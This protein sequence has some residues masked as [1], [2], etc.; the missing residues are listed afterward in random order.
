MPPAPAPAPAASAVNLPTAPGATSDPNQAL[1]NEQNYQSQM[2]TGSQ[3]QTAEEN[4][5]GVGAAQTQVSGLRQAITNTTNLLNQV[6]PSVYGRTQSSLET[7]AQAGRQISNE[8]APISSNLKSQTTAEANAESDYNNL[9]KEATTKASMDESS[10]Q[11][12]LTNLENTY[13]DLYTQQQAQQ[14][15]AANAAAEAEKQSEFQQTLSEKTQNDQATQNS[16][17]IKAQAASTKAGTPSASQNTQAAIQGMYSQLSSQKGSDGFISPQSYAKG[18]QAWVSA[19]LNA[20]DYDTYFAT[21][22]N[23]N[24][25]AYLLSTG[26]YSGQGSKSSSAGSSILSKLGI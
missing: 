12:E 3:L 1:T 24:N 11:A 26:K 21:L 19:G 15:A 9:E 16:N 6:A 20:K 10:Q 25:G 14:T 22:R 23:P 2:Q 7:Q 17:L 5:L 13:K 8:Q 18:M 4:A